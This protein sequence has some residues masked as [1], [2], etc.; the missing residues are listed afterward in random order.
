MYKR[1]NYLASSLTPE[2][3]SYGYMRGNMVQF[4]IGGYIY[5]MPGIITSLTY[6]LEADSTWE[7]G[8]NTSGKVDTSVKQ[9]PHILKVTCNF[10]PIQ[11]FRPEIQNYD[12]DYKHYISLE[13]STGNSYGTG[14][15]PPDVVPVD[16]P[17]T[18]V[19]ETTN[20][21]GKNLVTPKLS[22]IKYTPPRYIP[23]DRYSIPDSDKFDGFGGGGGF[24]GGGAG[25]SWRQ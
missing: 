2:Y 17:P 9:L 5:E 18:P 25:G 3:S 1:L 20:T 11:K 14:S 13:D 19:P 4:T 12:D 16:I 8:I 24:N 10:T 22:A 21:D 23:D 15:V 6:T 7:I